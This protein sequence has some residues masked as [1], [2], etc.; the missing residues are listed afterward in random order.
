MLDQQRVAAGA[1]ERVVDLVKAVEID[2]RE[3]DIASA[4]RRAKRLR[5]GVRA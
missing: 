3:G 4:R 1:A 5:R 2:Q